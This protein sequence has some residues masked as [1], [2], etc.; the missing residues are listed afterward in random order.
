M[1]TR[2]RLRLTP[3]KERGSLLDARLSHS[4]QLLQR[5]AKIIGEPFWG[6]F[7]GGK[8][9]VVIKEVARLAGVPVELHYNVTTIDPPELVH[10]IRKEHAD[11]SFDRPKK[12]FF[13]VALESGRFPTRRVRWC[14]EVF[15]ESQT[16]QGRTMIFGVRAAESPRRAKAWQDVTMH[17]RTN[18][19]VVSPILRWSDAMVW[20]F[21]LG[22]GLSYC[23][24]YD[25]G[26]DR[27]GCIGCPM[28]GKKGRLKQFARWPGYE[29]KWKQLFNRLWERK[30]GSTQRDG[31][32]WFGDRYFSNWQE[33]WDWWLND[34]PLPSDKCQGGLLEMLSVGDND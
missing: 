7:S 28:S 8:D 2:E 13:T 15:K 12:N 21:I 30:T 9:S 17:T 3:I 4:I 1:S 23:H 10:F 31:R 5:M 16:P 25:E 6:C 14:C 18:A 20:M 22:R 32:V 33:M 34:K 19:N 27:L 24:L 26:F 11:V 29:R